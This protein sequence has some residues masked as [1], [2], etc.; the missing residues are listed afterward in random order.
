MRRFAKA[1][2]AFF[3]TPVLRT[4]ILELEYKNRR[5]L[6]EVAGQEN[7]IELLTLQRNQAILE[8][9]GK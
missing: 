2:K 6:D 1:I 9:G 5:L 4:R 7:I 3:D 8:R